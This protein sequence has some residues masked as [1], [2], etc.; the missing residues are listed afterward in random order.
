MNRTNSILKKR[1]LTFHVASLKQTFWFGKTFHHFVNKE[2][3]FVH[4]VQP[5]IW[6]V[7]VSH[8]Y[9]TQSPEFATQT[10][11][12]PT[13]LHICLSSPFSAALCRSN[14]TTGEPKLPTETLCSG[15]SSTPAP[16]TDPS[17]GS[18][19]G[20]WMKL[21]LV[22]LCRWQKGNGCSNCRSFLDREYQSEYLAGMH[23]SKLYLFDIGTTVFGKHF[24]L[25]EV[26]EFSRFPCSMGRSIAALA[27]HLCIIYG[28]RFLI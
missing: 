16:S 21:V 28:Q 24:L 25:W 1:R 18:A 13:R 19:K 22:S 15:C 4:F 23:E 5:V 9:G 26:L 12:Y 8:I 2:S 10:A 6:K 11:H 14:A 17:F 3:S 20:S 27:L 7:Q